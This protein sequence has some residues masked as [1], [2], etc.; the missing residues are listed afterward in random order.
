MA[1]LFFAVRCNANISE[2]EQKM[3]FRLWGRVG[4]YD[5]PAFLYYRFVYQ[6]AGGLCQHCGC[7]GQYFV[8]HR[9]RYRLQFL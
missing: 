1:F 7:I 3:A 4:L 2:P 8:L 5:Q 9:R 6:R